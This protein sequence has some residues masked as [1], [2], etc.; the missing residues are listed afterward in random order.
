[1][2]KA[3]AVYVMPSC[4][5]CDEAITDAPFGVA[6]NPE[7]FCSLVCCKIFYCRPLRW[8]AQHRKE[9]PNARPL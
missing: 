9:R 1:M 7:L 8:I 6:D 3:L 4:D 5:M 2:G